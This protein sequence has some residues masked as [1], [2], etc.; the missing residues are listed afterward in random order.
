[1]KIIIEITESEQQ[2]IDWKI[3]TENNKTQ[4]WSLRDYNVV[5]VSEGEEKESG[6]GKACQEM[7]AAISPIW[8]KTSAYGV[9]KLNESHTG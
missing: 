4:P 6:T 8:Q 9:K 5:R 1:M 2:K 3:N 7:M